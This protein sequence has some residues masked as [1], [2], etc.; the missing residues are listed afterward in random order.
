MPLVAGAS[1]VGVLGVAWSEPGRLAG[2]AEVELV[3]GW[4]ELVGAVIDRAGRPRG[5][6]WLPGRAERY[7]ALSEQIPAVLY[8]EVHIPGG[9]VVYESPQYQQL[10]GYTVED[11]MRPD[12]WMTLVHPDRDR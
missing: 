1:V 2:D 6:G 3:A 11:A 7:R 10:F 12:F 9:A 4:G 5:Q 8:S